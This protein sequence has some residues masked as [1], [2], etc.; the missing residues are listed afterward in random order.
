MDF[1]CYDAENERHSK[2]TQLCASNRMIRYDGNI[3]ETENFDSSNRKH[4]LM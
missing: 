2:K 3:L 4:L 1:H